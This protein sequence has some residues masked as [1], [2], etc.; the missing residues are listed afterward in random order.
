MMSEL[1]K[2]I[3]SYFGDLPTTDLKKIASYFE[4]TRLSKGAYISKANKKCNLL[5]FVQKGYLRIFAVN[6][7]KEITQWISSEG[8]FSTDLSSFMFDTPAKWNIQAMVDCDVYMIT[9]NNY[10]KFE[11]EVHKW[12]ELEKL[13][14]V[15]CFTILENRIFNH[16]ALSAEER[17]ELFFKS[18]AGL[19]NQIPL[20]YIASML[21]MTPETLSRIRRKQ[22]L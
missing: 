21:G 20:Q 14:L 2:Y 15:R 10:R 8:Y 1:E 22:L 4:L 18:N 11:K 13:F 19:F 9:K 12:S 17:Y 7:G 6:N 5:C 16:I 3:Q